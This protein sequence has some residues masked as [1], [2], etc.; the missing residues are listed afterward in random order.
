[1]ID[2]KTTQPQK[3]FKILL[4]GDT[5]L[6]IYHYGTVERI[7]PEAPVPI[8]NFHHAV[9]KNGMA[10]NVKEN[11]D[12]LGCIVDCHYGLKSSVK[13]RL[14]D[15]K[16]NQHL[17]RIDQDAISKPLKSYNVGSTYDAIVVSD[18]NKGAVT[19]EL[20]QDM[21]KQFSGPIFVDTKKN[22]LAKLEG[23]IVKIN[24][25]EYN[26]AISYCTDLVVTHGSKPVTYQDKEF[27]VPQVDVFD[28]CG[29]GDTF[30]ATLVVKY[31]QVKSIHRAIYYAINAST[32]TVQKNGVYAPTWE[33]I[34]AIDW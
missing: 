21:R 7:S 23:C 8:F 6:D 31:L 19:Y 27:P 25:K 28:V 10:A 2:S 29:A 14:I 9:Q 15:M 3:Q 4:V 30:L 26:D 17:M 24:E 22:D 5:C 1:M 34:N 16:S 33:E 13:T 20:I 11:L 32:V 18:Y 12:N